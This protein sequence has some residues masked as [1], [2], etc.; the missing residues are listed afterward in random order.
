[1]KKIPRRVPLRRSLPRSNQRRRVQS[2]PVGDAQGT[3]ADA[4]AAAR[5][6]PMKTI[7]I[8]IFDDVEE[9]DFAGPYEVFGMA[10]R[11]GADC[12]TLLI[13]EERREVRCRHG[14]RVM[15]DATID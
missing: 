5:S 2:D 9:L 6:D 8:L 14:M 15:P 13:A 1:M 4:L 11:F 7:G 12:R 10:A 3:R